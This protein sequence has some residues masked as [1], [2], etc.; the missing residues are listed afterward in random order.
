[1]SIR[2]AAA[3]LLVPLLGGC[4][5]VAHGP[6]VVPYSEN[7]FYIR[8]VPLIDS[9]QNVNALADRICGETGKTAW[10]ERSV[11]YAPI[12]VRDSTYRCVNS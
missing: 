3:L 4:A 1:M 9:T 6:R 10:L 8:Y 2:I 11:Q 7:R 12:D 5:E